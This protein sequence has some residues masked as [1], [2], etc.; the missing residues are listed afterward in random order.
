MQKKYLL[1]L[2]LFSFLALDV[3][4]QNTVGL[5]SYNESKAYDGYNLIY[6]HNQPNVYLLDNCGE[7]VHV[8]EDDANWRP[9]N[10]AYLMPNGN[11]I[12]TKR[13]AGAT[14]SSPIW[15]GGGGAMVEVKDWDNNL[16]ASFERNDEFERLHHDIAVTGD[17]TILMIV[18]ELRTIEECLQAGR[19]T[20]KL[21]QAK[22]WPDK[23]V[24]WDPATDE[25][26]WEWH[27][28]DHLVQD[29]DATKDNFGVV[30]DSP[31]KVDV[32]YDT[33]D[34]HPDWMHVNAID[35][36]EINDL[37]VISV[38]TFSEAWV[39]DHSTT[40]A[41]AAGSNGGFGGR[42]GDLLYRWGNPQTYGQGDSTNQ[43]LFYP[44]DIHFIDDH[45]TGANPQFGKM[46]AF[47]NRVGD[48][49]STVNIWNQG[50]DMYKF[51]F[52]FDGDK[53][54]PDDFDVTLMHPEPTK[55]YSTGLSSFQVLPNGNSLICSGRFGYS[56]ELTPNNEIVWEYRT[57]IRAGAFVAQGD[58]LMINNNLTFRMD[59]YPTD[60]SAFDGRDLSPQG[61]LE[62]N[63]DPDNCAKL[64]PTKDLLE[65]FDL[66]VFPNPTDNMLTITW[67]AGK[68][69]DV[70]I[71]NQFGQRVV[72]PMNLTGG[73]KYFD[74]TEFPNGIYIIRINGLQVTKFMVAR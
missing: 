63:A 46:A 14:G 69:V 8:W 21:A 28:W 49:F 59:R 42:G 6:P 39:I 32:N 60:F 15:A 29:F 54:G 68:F 50:F 40:T 74:T 27:T 58:S 71:Y 23:I 34:G 56:F 51:Q 36:Q 11:I 2:V 5:L 12:K 20:S 70:E 45:L 18:W 57:P 53:F 52:P 25:I 65:E 48:D 30:A 62:L 1:T 9:G 73:R 13:D 66:N 44:H 37:I 35:Y 43:K 16:I 19:D 67:D 47:N 41:Q 24:E 61:A 3:F 26:I 31:E 33:S 72:E 64:T 55:L 4:S 17:N 38:P 22:M 7:V 10:T